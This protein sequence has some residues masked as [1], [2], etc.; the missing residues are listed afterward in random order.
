[1]LGPVVDTIIVCTM[2]A[3][4][5]IMTGVWNVGESDGITLT[6][7]AFE[8]AMPGWG[9]Y[10]L[11]ICVAVFSVSTMLSFPYTEP[12]VSPLF[13]VPNETTFTSGSTSSPSPWEQQPPWVQLWV[14]STE[15]MR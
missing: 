6:A 11:T 4:A 9:S 10:L 14:Y 12:N 5:L 13:S 2:T 15:P 1:M 3:L 7:D 8:Q